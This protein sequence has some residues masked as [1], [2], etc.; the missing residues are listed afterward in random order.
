MKKLLRF[1][2]PYKKQIALATLFMLISVV[3]NL[4]LP[5]I[6]S[7]ILDQGVY[8]TAG[9]Y[10]QIV[11]SCLWMLALAGLSL[12]AVLAGYYFATRIT[13]FFTRDLRNAMFQKINEMSFEQVGKLG[14]AALVTRMTHDA[15]TLAWA[16]GLL[17]GSIV[18]IPLMFL[19]GTALCMQKDFY[20]S[21]IMLATVPLVLGLVLILSKKLASLWEISDKYFDVQ[22]GLMRERIRGI[23]VIRAF[24][25]EPREHERIYAA[26]T[27]MT[28]HMIRANVTMELIAPIAT[29]LMNLA[30]LGIVRFGAVRLER[31]AGLS[32]GDIFAV[33]QY[34]SIVL[35]SLISAMWAIIMLPHARVAARR[36][37]EIT[38]TETTPEACDESVQFSGEITL[39]HVSFRYEGADAAA[40]ED[41]SL[42]IPAGSRVAVIGGTG[43]GKS[44]LVSLLLAFRRPT[45]GTVRFDG[46]DAAEYS[47]S[48]IRRNVSCALQ[49]PM[50]YAGTIADNIR[51]GDLSASDAQV[52]EA[53]EI[54]QL[55]GLISR[56]E[57][58][59]GH[60]LT[61]SGGNISGGQK[62]RV[63][64][65]RAIVK[66]AP[67][68]IFD[69]SF[70]ALDFL[71]E[72][73]LRTALNERIR[74]RTQLI[75]SQRVTTAMRSDRIFV[76]D[77]GRLVGAGTHQEL[78][79]SCP[80]YREIYASQTGG[81]AA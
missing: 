21:L 42:H 54:A 32:A 77:Q 63:S 23:R 19:G 44:T 7:R 29:V 81:G 69:D 66:Q 15:G 61:P 60:V 64:I 39:E 76:L 56:R 4:T 30:V 52:A 2:L 9:S 68:Y 62:Q 27:E 75:I 59:L 65:A 22:N 3:C 67:I 8:G 34:V 5:T 49:R 57:K 72:K 25:R 37:S 55:S 16:A 31:G 53:A 71:T 13:A 78:L 38:D 36:I 26:I 11:R 18:I 43:S 47:G 48:T 79:E 1:L 73:A 80:I 6:M 28:G 70:S 33:I 10:A 12:G 51:M 46:V 40:L 74:G 20:L 17:C 14:T 41:I 35:S 50:L 58:G 45:E 24:S